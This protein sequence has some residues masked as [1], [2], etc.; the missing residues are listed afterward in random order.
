M[1]KDLF[2][3]VDLPHVCGEFSDTG[4]LRHYL[5][6]YQVLEESPAQEALGGL[7]SD[8]LHT[9]LIHTLQNIKTYVKRHAATKQGKSAFDAGVVYPKV[10]P[11]ESDALYQ[12]MSYVYSTI[13]LIVNSYSGHVYS[14]KAESQSYQE[15]VIS[16]LRR[17]THFLDKI[18][19]VRTTAHVTFSRTG[20]D[21]HAL[22]AYLKRDIGKSPNGWSLDV[23]SETRKKF[24]DLIQKIARESDIFLHKMNASDSTGKETPLQNKTLSFTLTALKV[25]DA[26]FNQCL[27]NASSLNLISTHEVTP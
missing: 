20:G 6:T 24:H 17:P 2:T 23:L 1:E 25:I 10:T 9:R 19:V 15:N 4:A 12:D 22:T 26:Q 5:L 27:H 21:A 16:A 18:D 13:S 14:N 3:Q 8:T 7:L 11:E